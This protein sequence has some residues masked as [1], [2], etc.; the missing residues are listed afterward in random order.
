MRMSHSFYKC[1]NFSV[2]PS[3]IRGAIPVI[4]MSLPTSMLRAQVYSPQ[5]LLKGQADPAD[6][7]EL[8]KGICERAGALTPRQKAEAI[9]RYF[10][11]DGRYVVP[12]FWY[13]IAGWAYEE[14][15]GEVLD[16]V[17]LLNNYGFGLCYQIAPLLEAVFEAAGF[18]DARVWFLTEHTVTEVFYDGSYHYFDSDMMGY[19][20]IGRG[21]PKQQPVASVSQIAEDG[22]IILGKLLS[23]NRVDS[24]RVDFPWYPADVKES[25]MGGLA[26]LFTSRKDNWLFPFSR[27]SLGHRMDFVLRPGEKLIRFYQPESDA[28]FYLPYKF[29]GQQWNE[30]PRE[31][32]EYQIRTADGPRSQRDARR[33]STGRIEYRPPLDDRRSYFPVFSP[34]FNE[35]IEIPQSHTN[36]SFLRRVKAD[37]PGQAVFEIRSPYVMID[38]KVEVDAALLEPTQRLEVEVSVDEGKQ[39]E[40]MGTKG[41]PFR[42]KWEVWPQVRSRSA[43]GALTS[44]SGKYHFLVRLRMSGP[45]S[46]DSLRVSDVQIVSRVQLNPRTLPDLSAGRNELIYTASKALVR[47]EIDPSL[48]RIGDFAH[49]LDKVRCIS[50]SGQSFLWPSGPGP[51]EVV[52]EL[53]A[54]EGTDLAGFDA[55]ARFLDLRDGLAPDKLTAEVRK[56][57]FQGSS[58][59]PRQVPQASLSWATRPD[60]TY[61]TLWEY[62]ADVKWLDGRPIGQ[63]LRWPEVD[64][65]VRDLPAGTRKVYVRYFL[66]GMGLDTPRLAVISRAADR[67]PSLQISHQWIVDGRIQEYV[68]RIESPWLAH[69]YQVDT[70]KGASIRNYAIIFYCP[71]Q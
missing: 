41:G 55:G 12:G 21:D 67:S 53:S 69:T 37:R 56:T 68:E 65:V 39:W 58:Q 35:N 3:L 43:H 32:S 20:S 8:A 5:V 33:W 7:K 22:S 38:A 17:K 54:P 71:P 46:T 70:G 45:G 24:T 44:V 2:L 66:S 6:L 51:A 57:S 11:T 27:Y 18:E 4:L 47:R 13:H 59:A 30:F 16:A 40:L 62:P 52:F 34:E 36:Q 10:L 28:L 50:E 15:G 26:E 48:E 23:P 61:T 60:G 64:R 49:R 25:A 42:G 14:P 29:D 63:L 1:F 31:V 9:W 19:N